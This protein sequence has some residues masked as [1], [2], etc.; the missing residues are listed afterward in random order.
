[1]F[2]PADRKCNA[3]SKLKRNILSLIWKRSVLSRSNFTIARVTRAQFAFYAIKSRNFWFLEDSPSHPFLSSTCLSRENRRPKPE[4]R[5]WLTIR[6]IAPS[7]DRHL[8]P[9]HP[10]PS[11]NIWNDILRFF[12]LEKWHS[13]WY[14]KVEMIGERMWTRIDHHPSEF[15]GKQECLRSCA[16][17]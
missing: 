14:S 17:F 4:K 13:I 12:R 5:T 10:P 11:S 8:A 7:S 2:W 1:M 6:E 9:A 16:T 15:H 3:F